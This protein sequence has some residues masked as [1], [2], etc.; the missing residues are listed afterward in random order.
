MFL[1]FKLARGKIEREIEEN[2]EQHELAVKQF[3]HQLTD[4]NQIIESLEKLAFKR[5]FEL[6]EQKV[7]YPF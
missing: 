6:E 5:G 1:D 2:T 3:E 7:I 4:A